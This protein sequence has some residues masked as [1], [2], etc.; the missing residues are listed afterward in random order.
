M[1]RLFRVV[2]SSTNKT[3]EF[4]SNKIEAKEL[5]NKLNPERGEHFI[6]GTRE[7]YYIAK[8]PDHRLYK[9]A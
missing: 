2:D 1:K 7:R 6:P 4:F 5:R 9:N 3:I 8:G